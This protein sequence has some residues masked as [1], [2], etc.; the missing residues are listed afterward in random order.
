MR[1][2]INVLSVCK[3]SVYRP[4]VALHRHA[5]HAGMDI[6]IQVGINARRARLRS[7]LSQD[8]A[9]F[10]ASLDRTYVG[11]LERGKVNATIESLAG[12]A[13]AL[14]IP[15]RDFRADDM[16]ALVSIP[17]RYAAY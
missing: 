9:A 10:N 5:F 17:G 7:G 1:R 2:D 4:Y 13:A 8:E 14:G 6:K 12:L 16:N 11:N 3:P 15:V